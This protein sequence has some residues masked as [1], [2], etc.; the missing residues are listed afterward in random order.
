M[1]ADLDTNYPALQL[2]VDILGVNA[3]GLEPANAWFTSV[4][5][6]PWLQDVDG[7]SNGQSDVWEAWQ[8]TYRDVIILD[9]DNERVATFNL[10]DQNLQLFENYS[11]LLRLFVDAASGNAIDGDFNGSGAVEQGDLDL[12]LLNWGDVVDQP[13]CGRLDTGPACGGG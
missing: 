11:A 13:R 5:D 3:A 10:T 1:Q 4:A 8:V 2:D 6:L 12:V 9:G 7:D